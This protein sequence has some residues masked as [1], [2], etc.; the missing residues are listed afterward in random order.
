MYLI[1]RISTSSIQN[2]P[3][4]WSIPSYQQNIQALGDQVD[5]NNDFI[6]TTNHTLLGSSC[7]DTFD[8]SI[9]YTIY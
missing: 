7:T 2:T 5:Q 9:V 3:I 8:D 4:F 1:F 6:K